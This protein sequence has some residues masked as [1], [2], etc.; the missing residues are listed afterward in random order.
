[1]P[2]KLG[3]GSSL[4]GKSVLYLGSMDSTDLEAKMGTKMNFDNCTILIYGHFDDF[5]PVGAKKLSA[6][7]V[8]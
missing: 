3:I 2:K 5:N 6:N 8:K 1:M 4:Y 7:F